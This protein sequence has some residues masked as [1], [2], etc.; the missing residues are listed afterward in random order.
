M[1]YSTLGK[2]TIPLTAHD[3]TTKTQLERDLS[4]ST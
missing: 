3:L 2:A 1:L 4:A